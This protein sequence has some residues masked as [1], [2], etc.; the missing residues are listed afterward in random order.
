MGS[1]L[2]TQVSLGREDVSR[3]FIWFAKESGARHRPNGKVDGFLNRT[4]GRTRF[5]PVFA[6]HRRDAG[7][8]VQQWNGTKAR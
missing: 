8:M 1:T 3:R 4:R 2:A 5:Y 6:A 7:V